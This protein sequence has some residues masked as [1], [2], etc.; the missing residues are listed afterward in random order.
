MPKK[1][2]VPEPHP[3]LRDLREMWAELLSCDWDSLAIVPTDTAVA[4]DILVSSLEESI[5][6]VN[7]TVRLVDARGSEIA[8]AKKTAKDVEGML[9]GGDRVVILLDPLTH[10]L[11]GV[12]V[13]QSVD[14]VLLSVQV[15]ALE[16]GAL[17]STV[18]IIGPGRI[19]GSVAATVGS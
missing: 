16:V 15:G 11:S 17:T 8:D 6:G 9:A 1:A 12:H 14:A 4:L 19:V 13:V 18:S 2:P 10:S 3:D 7:P 5:Q